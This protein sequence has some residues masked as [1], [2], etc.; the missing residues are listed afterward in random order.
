MRRGAKP[1]TPPARTA[2]DDR[3]LLNWL[4][5]R[6]VEDGKHCHPDHMYERVLVEHRLRLARRLRLSVQPGVYLPR[7]EQPQKRRIRKAA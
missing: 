5:M 7:P 6:V 1:Y 2:E 4:S 3:S